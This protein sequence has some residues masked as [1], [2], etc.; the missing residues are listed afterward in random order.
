MTA[1]GS[2]RIPPDCGNIS[3]MIRAPTNLSTPQEPSAGTCEDISF[4]SFNTQDVTGVTGITGIKW[5]RDLQEPSTG[6]PDK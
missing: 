5:K 2:V 3:P 6:T 4:S 1:T